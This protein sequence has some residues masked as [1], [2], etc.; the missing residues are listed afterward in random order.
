MTNMCNCE[1][2]KIAISALTDKIRN[3]QWCHPIIKYANE[4]QEIMKISCTCPNSR[5]DNFQGDFH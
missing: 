2:K 4:I 5:D 3:T 1:C